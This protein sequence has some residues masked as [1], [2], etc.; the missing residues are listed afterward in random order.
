[1]RDELWEGI[2]FE[3][4]ENLDKKMTY[5]AAMFAFDT[6]ARAGEATATGGITEVHTI[7]AKEVI[8][9]LERPVLRQGESVYSVRGGADP[10]GM[11][12]QYRYAL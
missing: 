6:A 3:G 11:C 9:H 1:M 2:P 5:I 10:R 12:E 7:L 8:I 4:A